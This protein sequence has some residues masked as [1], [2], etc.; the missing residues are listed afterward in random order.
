MIQKNIFHHNI[1]LWVVPRYAWSPSDIDEC[2]KMNICDEHASC[3]NTQ[4]SYN[5]ACNPK[6]IGDGLTCKG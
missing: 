1:Q 5:C 6:Y 4:G 3:S 2:S